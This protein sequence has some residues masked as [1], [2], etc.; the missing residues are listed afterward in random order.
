MLFVVGEN[1]SGRRLKVALKLS[2]DVIPFNDAIPFN[3]ELVLKLY[4]LAVVRK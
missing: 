3:P 2:T 1:F 4:R